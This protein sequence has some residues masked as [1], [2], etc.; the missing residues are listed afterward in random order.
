M[1]VEIAEVLNPDG[2]TQKCWILMVKLYNS[3]TYLPLQPSL[4]TIFALTLTISALMWTIFRQ[5]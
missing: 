3:D 4:L 5:S 2:K 1:T